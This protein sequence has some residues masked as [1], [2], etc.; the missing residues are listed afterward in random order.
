ML[1][2][3]Q[4]ETIQQLMKTSADDVM[5][6]KQTKT[7]IELAHKFLDRLQTSNSIVN[8]ETALAQ[9]YSNLAIADQLVLLNR[10]LGLLTQIMMQ[11]RQGGIVVPQGLNL[12]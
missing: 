3:E 7:N 12:K 1:T 5:D 4:E 2:K 11:Q 9:V 10:S 6:S 8:K